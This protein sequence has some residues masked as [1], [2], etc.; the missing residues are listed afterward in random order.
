MGDKLFSAL[1]LL[2]HRRNIAT[3][4]L[5]YHWF[6]GKCSDKLHYIQDIQGLKKKKLLKN[7]SKIFRA[8]FIVEHILLPVLVS[9][10]LAKICD[11]ECEFLGRQADA[12]QMEN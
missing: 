2:S 5:L 1:Q 12:L 6:L 11:F 7:I 3:F 8:I 10:T 4:S 9:S